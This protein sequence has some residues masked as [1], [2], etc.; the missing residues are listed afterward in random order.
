MAGKPK[1]NNAKMLDLQSYIKAGID[2]KTGL[3]IRYSQGDDKLQEGIKKVLRIKDEQIATNRY[4]WYNTG[5]NITSQEIERLLYYKYSL[6]FF[7]LDGQPYLMPYALDGSIDFYGRENTV[8]P[9]PINSSNNDATKRQRNLLSQI[10]LDVKRGV[11]LEPNMKDLKNSG[12]IIKDYTPQMDITSGIPRYLLQDS[13]IDLESKIFPYMRTAMMNS[14]GTQAV[15]CSDSSEAE[16]II[17][18]ANTF[19]TAALTGT[20]LIP[21]MG[22]LNLQAINHG[23]VTNSEEYL[24]TMQGIDNFRESL[25]G[26]ANGG[27]FTKKEHTND[28]ENALNIQQDFPLMDGLKLRQDACDIINSIWPIGIWCEISETAAGADKNGDMFA[29][30]SG[31]PTNGTESPEGGG[32]ESNQEE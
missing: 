2:P 16:D 3:P 28:S 30:D 5:L 21:I 4:V 13:V 6:V 11:V 19:D 22:K 26:V 7:V 24:M 17:E 18:A 15:Q 14:T 27:L 23:S 8:H 10:K 29:D 31:E 9:I 25:Y 12:V 20:P 1:K 32:N